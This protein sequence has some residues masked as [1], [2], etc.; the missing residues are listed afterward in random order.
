ML[1]SGPGFISPSELRGIVGF[2]SYHTLQ[3]VVLTR[4]AWPNAVLRWPVLALNTV[5]LIAIPIHGG[6]HFVDLLGGIVVAIVAIMMVRATIATAASCSGSRLRRV[7]G[8]EARYGTLARA[9]AAKRPLHREG[10]TRS[11]KRVLLGGA[12]RSCAGLVVRFRIET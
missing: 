2:P 1:R 11:A 12:G 4:F 8:Q 3:A 6:H 5:G 9:S 7:G 10:V